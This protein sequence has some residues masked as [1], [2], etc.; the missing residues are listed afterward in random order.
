VDRWAPDRLP[1]VLADWYAGSVVP[2]G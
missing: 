1:D 2:R